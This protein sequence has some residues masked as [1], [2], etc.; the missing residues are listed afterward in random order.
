MLS[1]FKHVSIGCKPDIALQ[2]CNPLTHCNLLHVIITAGWCVRFKGNL[3][4][5]ILMPLGWK[6]FYIFYLCRNFL[7]LFSCKS[8]KGDMHCNP[9]QFNFFPFT[10]TCLN[11]ILPPNARKKL[12]CTYHVMMLCYKPGISVS[13][14]FVS[15][16]CK[17]VL[18]FLV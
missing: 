18:T 3:C 14:F 6:S 15:I 1:L 5:K 7:Q 9:I 4:L 13:N 11:K 8:L 16:N 10:S 17:Q 2:I 12:F